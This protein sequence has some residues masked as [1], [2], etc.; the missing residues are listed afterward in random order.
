MLQV[1]DGFLVFPVGLDN[2]ALDGASDHTEGMGFYLNNAETLLTL[3]AAA[4][5][6][7]VAQIDRLITDSQLGA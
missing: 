4:L 3:Q 7:I 1:D 5:P 6:L 2:H